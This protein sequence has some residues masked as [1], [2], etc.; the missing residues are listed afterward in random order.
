M[1]NICVRKFTSKCENIDMWKDTSR[2]W[3]GSLV[4]FQCENWKNNLYTLD[5]LEGAARKQLSKDRTGE[6]REFFQLPTK[7]YIKK[8][9]LDIYQWF[10]KSLHTL[11]N[12]WSHSLRE[13]ER[14]CYSSKMNAAYFR[15]H[16]MLLCSEKCFICS[17]RFDFN[18][19]A[20]QRKW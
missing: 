3:L 1:I 10:V 11:E 4:P 19:N 13:K 5:R 6:K 15:H 18:N 9:A 20:K 8:I 14:D 16:T 7:W 12:V 2:V 17:K